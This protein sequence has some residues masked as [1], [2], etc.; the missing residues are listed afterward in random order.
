MIVKSISDRLHM[1]KVA[2][3]GANGYIGRHLTGYLYRRNIDFQLFDIQETS[4]DGISVYSK[5][6]VT[7][8]KWWEAFDPTDFNVVFFLVGLSGPERSFQIAERYEDVNVRGLLL[9]MQKVSYLGKKA[10]KIIFPS[11]RLVYRGGGSVTEESPLE[12]RSVYAANK[13]ACESLL[14]A[15]YHRYGMPFVALRICVPFG[16][17]VSK[18]YSYGTLGFFMQQVMSGKPITVY[19]DG[20]CTK[21]YTYIEDLCL[22]C[23]KVMVT[24]GAIG[25]YNVGGHDYSLKEVA[26]MVVKKHGG[27]I[28]YVPWPE[29]ALRVEMGNISLNATKLADVIGFIEYKRM[30]NLTNVF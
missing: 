30:E 2:I 27:R 24:A 18:E 12:A 4:A 15:Y 16:N 28:E 10:P 14:S 17:I 11:S 26:E 21:T 6:D 19:G 22:V 9:L 29:E 13:I 7:D 25:V 5:C 1:F 3:F 23:H 8:D 20:Q